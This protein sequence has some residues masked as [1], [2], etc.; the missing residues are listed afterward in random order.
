MRMVALEEDNRFPAAGLETR[1]DAVGLS[2]NLVQ[3]ILIALDIGTAGRS[4]LD[5]G[6]VALVGRVKLE[7]KL[8]GPDALENALGVVDAINANPKKLGSNVQ[9]IKI[10]RASCR[11]RV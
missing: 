10:G 6:K 11:E 2:G 7:K 1:V 4:D 3:Q 5:K 9:L 8:D